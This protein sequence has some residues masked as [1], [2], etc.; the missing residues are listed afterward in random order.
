M[1]GRHRITLQEPTT[2]DT[3]GGGWTEAW[4]DIAT[5]RGTVEPL[6]GFEQIQAMQA[7]VERPYR[8]TVWYREDISGA[9]RAILHARGGDRTLNVR[10]VID[11]NERHR[12]LQILADEVVS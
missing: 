7:G 2:A 10:S 8:I 12:K 5:V 3:A 11:L 4:A 6:D 9:T 1:I